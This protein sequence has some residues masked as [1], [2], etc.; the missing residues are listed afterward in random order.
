MLDPRFIAIARGLP[1]RAK[2]DALFLGRLQM[3]LDA[4]LGRRPLDGRPPPQVYANGGLSNFVRK[5]SVSSS[6][7]VRKV[8]QR[9]NG[10]NRLPAASAHLARGLVQEF[11]SRPELLSPI[12]GLGILS[13]QWM[14]QVMDGSLEPSASA[15]SMVMNILAVAN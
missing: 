15:L 13:P 7:I 4:D 12:V 1:A 8:W 2:Y 14:D 9:V 11:R 3:E 6:R 5:R 10:S